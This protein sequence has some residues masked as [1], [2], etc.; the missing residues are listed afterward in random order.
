M[1]TEK[2][3]NKKTLIMDKIFN[4][5]SHSQSFFEMIKISDNRQNIEFIIEFLIQAI[6]LNE[7]EIF[8]DY[9]LWLEDVLVNRGLKKNDYIFL[10]EK[11]KDVVLEFSEEE[12]VSILFNK[13]IKKVKNNSEDFFSSYHKVKETKYSKKFLNYLLKKDRISAQKMIMDLVDNGKSIEYIYKNIFMKTLIKTG[14]LWQVNEITIAD[15]H[16]NTAVIQSIIGQLYPNLFKNP[17]TKKKV[18]CLS[19]TQELHQVGIRMIADLF[20]IDGWDAHYFGEYNTKEFINE[21]VKNNKPEIIIIS[22][23]LAKNIEYVEK[24]ISD[25]RKNFSYNF[26][27]FVGGLAFSMHSDIYKKIGADFSIQDTKLLLKKANNLL[28][29]NKI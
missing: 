23:T 4:E 9:I 29:D 6:K 25:L 22:T 27:I 7:D 12:Y 17:P 8:I 10:L 1:K 5:M 18:F 13:S 19:N 15:E 16:Y 14:K 24:I 2:W 3:L 21:S 26:Y 28:K 11:I 20:T